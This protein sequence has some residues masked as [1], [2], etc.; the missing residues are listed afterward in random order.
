M[1]RTPEGCST[2]GNLQLAETCSRQPPQCSEFTSCFVGYTP[3]TMS[4]VED[5]ALH[6]PL[7]VFTPQRYTPKTSKIF[8]KRI[9]PFFLFTH[10]LQ[11]I[12][13][14][15][16]FTYFF[17]LPP[18]SSRHHFHPSICTAHIFYPTFFPFFHF[19]Y[20]L[21]FPPFLPPHLTCPVLPPL[22]LFK[23]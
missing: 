23:G 19:V 15:V 7:S 20:Y 14:Y 3:P 1:A 4:N 13:F 8:F 11:I 17:F 2:T 10:L 16:S 18:P 12:S 22:I 21:H 5:V 6:S 9:N